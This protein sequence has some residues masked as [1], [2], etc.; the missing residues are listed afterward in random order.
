[1]INGILLTQYNGKILGPI[2]KLL[3]ICLN[4]IFNL[5]NMIGIPNV[6][7]AI[8]IFTIVIY[9]C[10][11]PLTI[12]QQK[13]SKLSAIMNPELTKIREKYKNKTDQD[14]M[15]RQNEEMQLVY[16]KYGVSPTG[17]CVQ[18]AIQMPILFAL[19]RVI[20]NIPAYVTLVKESLSGLA[21]EIL[22][23]SGG[24][25]FIASFNTATKY[26]SKS[27]FS[28]TDT[29]IDVLSKASSDEWDS[30]IAKFPDLVNFDSARMLFEKYNDFLGLNISDTPSF[31]VKNA[32]ANGNFLL[33][34]GALMIPIL[35][36]AS[37]W[38]NYLFMPQPEN[39][40][41][42][43]M[44]KSM[45]SMNIMMPLMSA[46]FCY[47]FPCGMGIYWISGAV[48]RSVE[49]VIINKAIDKMDYEKIIQ[50]NQE[51]YEKQKSKIKE[52]GSKSIASHA[53][54]STKGVSGKANKNTSGKDYDS[55]HQNAKPGSIAAKANRVRDYNEKNSQKN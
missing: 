23:I 22:N 17:S 2:A 13:F 33:I 35:A 6:G 45:K 40:D 43:P 7:L 19:Y 38:L 5:L 20:N 42:N 31:I 48:V 12:K 21:E 32:F 9:L 3:G 28:L 4:W 54:I 27:D 36:A 25:E 51:K 47:S 53:G 41:D 1:M 46:F 10:L 14:S 50:K 26:F 52:T 8:I 16:K 24:S 11:L 55:Y 29:I 15:Q 34:I 39:M 44:A 37:Q 18:L 49:Q 30:I